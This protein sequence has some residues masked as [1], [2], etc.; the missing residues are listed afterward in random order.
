MNANPIRQELLEKALSWFAGKDDKLICA[1]MGKHQHDKNANELWL[2]FQT[3]IAWVKA[4]FPVYRKEMEGDHIIPWS[5]GGKTT[6]ENLQM[7]CR[8]CNNTKSDK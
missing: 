2:Y 6:I 1:Y 5:K 3:V 8:A 4:L 7:L